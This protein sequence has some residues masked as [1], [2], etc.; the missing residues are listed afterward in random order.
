VKISL[1]KENFQETRHLL[2]KEECSFNFC[3]LNHKASGQSVCY[4]CI[5]DTSVCIILRCLRWW[6][7]AL[8]WAI[9]Y[10]CRTPVFWSRSQDAWNHIIREAIENELHSDNMNRQDGFSVSRSWKPLFR[11]LK[12]QRQALTKNMTPSGGT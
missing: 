7:T 1:V 3:T 8:T 12:E 11:D 9:I 4:N 2:L 10:S 6:N 5:T